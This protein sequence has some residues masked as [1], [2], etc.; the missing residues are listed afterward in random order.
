M[1]R[2]DRRE[3][4]VTQAIGPARRGLRTAFGF[5]RTRV[6]DT[7]TGA[8]KKTV[9]MAQAERYAFVVENFDHHSSMNWRYQFFYYLDT[10]EIEMVRQFPTNHSPV[11][12][13]ED[14]ATPVLYPQR[15]VA[16]YSPLAF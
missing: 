13:L 8:N 10:K 11:P 14:L 1:C 3:G 4:A 9:N 15:D 16:L 5:Y 12:P 7:E 2:R 6:L